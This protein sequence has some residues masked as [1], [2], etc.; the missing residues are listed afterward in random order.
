[1]KYVKSK[2]QFS[3]LMVEGINYDEEIYFFYNHCYNL[4]KNPN[5]DKCIAKNTENKRKNLYPRRPVITVT[6]FSITPKVECYKEFREY[7]MKIKPTRSEYQVIGGGIPFDKASDIKV[8]YIYDISEKGKASLVG[9]AFDYL[10]RI[11]ICK[12]SKCKFKLN[13]TIGYNWLQDNINYFSRINKELL[14]KTKILMDELDMKIESYMSNDNDLFSDTILEGLCILSRLEGAFRGGIYDL[15]G[16]EKRLLMKYDDV[17]DDLKN[18]GKHFIE[19]FIQVLNINENSKIIL[20]P[21]FGSMYSG[22]KADGDVI[23]DGCLIDFKVSKNYKYQGKEACQI[24]TYY[25][26]NEFNKQNTNIKTTFDISSIAL[27]NV[28]YGKILKYD[29]ANKVSVEKREEIIKSL[30]F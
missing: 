24:T 27:Y 14:K 8:P 22:F 25:M 10:A 28:R 26:L 2:K 4:Y 13:E 29:I 12:Y 11:I 17:I 1:M 6:K 23:I 7:I 9:I 21:T 18:L 15:D 16:Y 19:D 3:L 30:I 5:N 20:N